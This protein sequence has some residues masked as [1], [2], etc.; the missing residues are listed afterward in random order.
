MSTGFILTSCQGSGSSILKYI[1]SSIP[2]SMITIVEDGIL[3][4]ALTWLSSIR[5]KPN[6]LR[7]SRLGMLIEIIAARKTKQ[8]KAVA[9]KL[10][11]VLQE[12][13]SSPE[14]WQRIENNDVDGLIQ[15]MVYLFYNVKDPKTQLW[16]DK[17]PEYLFYLKDIHRIFPQQKF[18][19]LVRHPYY[20]IR[21]N[22]IKR[23]K[24]INEPR[25]NILDCVNQWVI[26]NQYITRFIENNPQ[27]SCIS[28]KYEALVMSP[29]QTLEQLE[30]FL[31]LRFA[32]QPKIQESIHHLKVNE[33]EQSDIH[34]KLITSNYTPSLIKL[35][36]QFGYDPFDLS[37]QT[38]KL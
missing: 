21:S 18:I 11:R 32:Q 38:H 27:A 22:W 35:A 31:N 37:F 15:D 2:N 29:T 1:L 6:M 17:Y 14:F 8:H 26:S 20:T 24:S 23:G 5:D 34:Y 10:E 7:F 13:Q 16:G 19:F 33:Y 30:D 25:R 12:Y 28:L 36:E 9:Q 3:L 4:N